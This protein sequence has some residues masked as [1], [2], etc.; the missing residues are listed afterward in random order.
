[1]KQYYEKPKLEIHGNLETITKSD[2]G[3]GF[4]EDDQQQSG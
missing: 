2:G 3:G 1:M 4:D